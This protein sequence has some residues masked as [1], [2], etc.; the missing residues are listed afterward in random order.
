MTVHV[1]CRGNWRHLTSGSFSYRSE[2][3][4]RLACYLVESIH[5]LLRLE[6]METMR[7]VT[8]VDVITSDRVSLDWHLTKA[9]AHLALP[10][11]WNMLGQFAEGEAVSGLFRMLLSVC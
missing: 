10:Q 4:H 6:D 5:H 3:E 1:C 8:G 9:L 2:R 7:G 11:D